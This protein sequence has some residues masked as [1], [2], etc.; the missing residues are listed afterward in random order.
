MSTEDYL[1]KV[2]LRKTLCFLFSG[3]AGVGK[4]FWATTLQKYL[5]ESGYKCHNSPF[6]RGV[7]DTANFMGWDGKKDGRGRKL[8][9][10]IGRAGRS[11][12]INMWAGSAFLS[13]EYSVGF[14]YDAVFIDDWRFKDEYHYII[15]NEPLYHPIRVRINAPNREIL[16]GSLAYDDISE[17]DLDDFVF[18][19]TI[20]NQED[21][22][23]QILEL[24][25]IATISEI[26]KMSSA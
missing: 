25:D 17:T 13:T 16:K 4:T 23:G 24:L 22:T 19:Y 10:E 9:Q 26:E 6:A 15:R 14:P 18:D 5:Q 7:K 2:S 11:Y 21:G 8:L 3:K 1:N 12:D 20:Y